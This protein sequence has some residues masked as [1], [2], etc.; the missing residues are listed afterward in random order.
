MAT[1]YNEHDPFAAAWLRELI[2]RGLIPPG[3][4]DTRDIRDVCPADLTGYVQC[5]FFAGIGGWS[6]AL[7]L[8]GW[9]DAR[10]VWTGSCPCQPLSSAGLRQGH[11]DERHLWPAFYR[12]VAECRPP[13]VF[14]EQVTSKD[15]RE[16]LAGVRVDLEALGYA[17]GCADLCAAGVGSP[18]VRQRLYWV[19]YRDGG[20]VETT[21]VSIRPDGQVAAAAFADGAA[22]A[23]RV[24]DS[25]FVGSRSSQPRDG[26][27]EVECRWPHDSSPNRRFTDGFGNEYR[28]P[29]PSIPFLD[30]GFPG[31]VD[32]IRAAGNAIVP[33]VGAVFIEAAEAAVVAAHGC[34]AMEVG[35]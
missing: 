26:A 22:Q 7:R 4:V 29:E 19:G 17:C 30:D 1:Y 31:I 15:G 11:A 32:C 20:R 3:D 8:A 21:D 2:A 10:E 13:V 12:L 5:H 34:R 9:P 28:I 23:L 35:R 14:G 6:E 24:S 27:K 33:Q 25:T 16:W 18:Q